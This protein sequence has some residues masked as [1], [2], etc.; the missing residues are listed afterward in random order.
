MAVTRTRAALA[1]Q[2][3]QLAAAHVTAVLGLEPTDF[4]EI[5]DR[6]ARHPES[7]TLSL[8]AREPLGGPVS[9]AAAA[10]APRRRRGTG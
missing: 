10:L 9:G 2:H 3:E 7:C 5:G 8:V 4:F 1:V 6:Y